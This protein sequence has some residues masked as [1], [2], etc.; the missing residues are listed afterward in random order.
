[1]SPGSTARQ[2]ASKPN[3]GSPPASS[4]SSVIVPSG[5]PS[6]HTTC[7]TAVPSLTASSRPANCSSQTTTRLPALDN[8]CV[9]CSAAKV[10]YTENGTAP[11][12]NAAVSTRWNSGRLV[13]ISATVSPLRTPSP[14]SPAAISRTRPAYSRQVIVTAPPGVRSA[15]SCGYRATVPW[16]ASQNVAGEA[17]SV[18]AASTP[19]C[20]TSPCHG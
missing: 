8:T 12:W 4:S 14:A 7:S 10:L 5:L 1:M 6:T 13:I 17:R 18:I 3:A 16:N 15:T 2:Q 19:C 11:R 9:I 20:A